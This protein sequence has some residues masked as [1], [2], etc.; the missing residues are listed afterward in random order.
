MSSNILGIGNKITVSINELDRLMMDLHNS[1]AGPS[2]VVEA[3][4]GQLQEYAE[5]IYSIARDIESVAE[6]LGDY[7]HD[8]IV[9]VES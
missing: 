6:D 7:A 2:W 4:D 1:K 5:D 3:S 9:K 8:I